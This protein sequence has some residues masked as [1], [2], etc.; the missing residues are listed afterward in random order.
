MLSY[1]LVSTLFTP[2]V[3]ILRRGRMYVLGRDRRCDFPLPSEV[4][5]RRHAEL[6]WHA[7]GG[8]L[9]VDLGSRNGTKVNGELVPER[10]KL[11]NG[12]SIWIG[13][14]NLRYRE[15]EGDIS[16]LLLEATPE[17][18]TTVGLSRDVFGKAA[19]GGFVF[20]GSYAGAE[21]LEIC[22]LI[23]FNEKNG[24]LNVS[25]GGA[26][27]TLAFRRG[28]VIRARFR[29]LA[30]EDA[31]TALLVTPAGTFEFLVGDPG[32]A[33]MRVGT[34]ALIMEAARRRDEGLDT[35]RFELDG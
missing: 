29:D 3:R 6:H 2:R 23:G 33:E 14:F 15:Y 31:A 19:E 28:N 9:V 7:D 12:D 1:C 5:S 27:G 4:V 32:E 11:K 10:Q 26:R 21:L 25:T 16:G 18:D 17:G 13:P 30:G 20:G 22:Q 24:L 8:F 34:E 35:A